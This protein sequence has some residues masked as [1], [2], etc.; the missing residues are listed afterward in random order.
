MTS[1]FTDDD[2]TQIL[3]AAVTERC[4]CGFISLF[5]V[6]AELTAIYVT[7]RTPDTQLAA[8]NELDAARQRADQTLTTLVTW[9]AT[10]YQDVSAA[11][12][13]RSPHLFAAILGGHRD[14]VRVGVYF[15][16]EVK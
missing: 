10:E 12:M 5:N 2:Y 8:K 7:A 13:F 9:P 3:I 4:R 16:D 6:R 1:M 11:N 14:S 15:W